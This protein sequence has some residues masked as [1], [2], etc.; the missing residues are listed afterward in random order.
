VVARPTGA[1]R[2]AV[3]GGTNRITTLVLLVGICLIMAALV[4]PAVRD[5]DQAGLISGALQLAWGEV[6]FTHAGFY[7]YDKQYGTYLLLA[8][9]YRLAPAADPVLTGNLFQV[10]LLTAALAAVALR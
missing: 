10:V 4:A 9:L 5:N 6:P 7:N 2:P 8:V 3:I 1:A